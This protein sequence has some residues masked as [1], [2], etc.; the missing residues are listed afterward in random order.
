MALMYMKQ[1]LL[2]L[3]SGII[4]HQVNCQKTMGAGLAKSLK[5]KYPKHY[6]EYLNTDQKLGNIVVTKITD[7]LF[8]VGLFGQYYYGRTP[9]TTYTNYRAFASG[10]SKIKRLQEETGLQVYMPDHIG[11]GLANGNW[12]II[13][14][15]ITDSNICVTI[16]QKE[17]K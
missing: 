8:I 2:E 16:V 14:K 1:D 5:K 12:D 17:G 7:C 10:L 15:L 13:Q 9:G 11:C 3:Q 6:F 4:V